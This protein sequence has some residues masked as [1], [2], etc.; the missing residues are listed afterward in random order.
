MK[1]VLLVLRFIVLHQTVPQVIRKCSNENTIIELRTTRAPTEAASVTDHCSQI[2]NNSTVNT[3]V[4]QTS[5]CMIQTNS[6]KIAPI[7]ILEEQVT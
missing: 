4:S 3:T 2:N 6:L 1:A 5:K 7:F